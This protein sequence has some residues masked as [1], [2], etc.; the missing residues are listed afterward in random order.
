MVGLVAG[1]IPVSDA[2]RPSG[3][4]NCSGGPDIT[5]GMIEFT[6]ESVTAAVENEVG[7]GSHSYSNTMA[8]GLDGLDL[9]ISAADAIM[10][11]VIL[12]KEVQGD[13]MVIITFDGTLCDAAG[14]TC[15]VCPE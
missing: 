1:D 4:A 5:Y 6:T 2:A 3:G 11:T 7:G 13:Q 8:G 14:G 15:A 9:T 12:G 10:R